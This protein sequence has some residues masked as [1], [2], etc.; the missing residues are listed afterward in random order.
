MDECTPDRGWLAQVECILTYGGNQ[1]DI[2]INYAVLVINMTACAFILGQESRE[3]QRRA[4]LSFLFVVSFQVGLC[5]MLGCAGISIIWCACAGWM[6]QRARNIPREQS[7][8]MNEETSRSCEPQLQTVCPQITL[9]LDA[10]AI[11]YYLLTTEFITTVAHIC[12]IL[13]GMLLYLPT[14]W[15]TL[16]AT[17]SSNAHQLL[18]GAADEE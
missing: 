3:N 17:G 5:L 16:L 10:A 18:R 13:M 15:T 7:D 14:A 9:V 1:T 8:A 11:L 2:A 12:A 6:I 4:L